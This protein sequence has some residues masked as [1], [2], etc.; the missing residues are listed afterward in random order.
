[1]I[2]CGFICIPE[3]AG[4]ERG[5]NHVLQTRKLL[6]ASPDSDKVMELCHVMDAA[7]IGLSAMGRVQELYGIVR[8][9]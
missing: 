9:S 2:H 7:K 5:T 8:C 6:S 4:K 3:F 1:M